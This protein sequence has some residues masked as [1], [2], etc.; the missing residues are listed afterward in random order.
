M[1]AG[2]VYVYGDPWI[3]MH[4]SQQLLGVDSQGGCKETALP[5]TPWYGSELPLEEGRVG[6]RWNMV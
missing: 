5:E 6:S 1:P 3:D 2:V 4:I